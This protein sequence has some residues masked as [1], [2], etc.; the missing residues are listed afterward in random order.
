MIAVA[1][2][3]NGAS[4]SDAVDL[5]S[6]TV[7]GLLMPAAWTTAA[8]TFLVCDTEGGTYQPLYNDS[9]TEVAV[10]SAG[11]VADRAIALAAIKDA[12]A[13]WRWLKLRSGT[14]ASPVNQGAARTIKI[15][16]K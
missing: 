5:S 12:I 7:A 15:I 2:I 6:N 16:L 9:G 4:Q 13:P 1:T 8:L 10:A 14:A 3:A 11:V